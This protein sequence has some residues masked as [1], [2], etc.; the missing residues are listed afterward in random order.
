MMHGRKG[1]RGTRENPYYSPT[2]FIA[3]RQ[4]L[5]LAIRPLD[6]FGSNIYADD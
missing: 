3:T 5:L 2:A 1:V 6:A 4:V